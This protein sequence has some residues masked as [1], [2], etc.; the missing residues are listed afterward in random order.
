MSGKRI[1]TEMLTQMSKQSL[2]YSRM[3]NYIRDDYD[4]FGICPAYGDSD[5]CCWPEGRYE[6]TNHAQQVGLL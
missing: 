4:C 1:R 3:R 6:K 5:V 2:K